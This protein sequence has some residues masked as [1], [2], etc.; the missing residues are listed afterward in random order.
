MVTIVPPKRLNFIRQ[1]VLSVVWEYR[2]IRNAT[3][4]QC[5]VGP[6]IQDGLF[7]PELLVCL[8][9]SDSEYE[10][11]M[12]LEGCVGSASGRYP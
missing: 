1:I 11:F 5:L 7:G 3:L 4:C 2:P 8:Y 10:S 9:Y 12:S 6:R